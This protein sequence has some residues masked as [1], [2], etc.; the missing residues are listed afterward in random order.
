[1]ESGE[2]NA[3]ADDQ[4]MLNARTLAANLPPWGEPPATRRARRADMPLS[5]DDLAMPIDQPAAMDRRFSATAIAR[6]KQLERE[7]VAE[8]VMPPMETLAASQQEELRS[9]ADSLSSEDRDSPRAAAK[10]A[11]TSG[12]KTIERLPETAPVERERHWIRQPQ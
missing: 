5:Y 3:L 6:E 1:M 4:V 2:L 9:V 8:L 10:L 12:E 11:S 7:R